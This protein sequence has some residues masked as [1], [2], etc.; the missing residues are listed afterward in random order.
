MITG[1]Y[2]DNY[3]ILESNTVF[4]FK[5]QSDL[6]LHFEFN[7][8]EKF[9]FNLR[10]IFETSEDAHN[11]KIGASENE[12]KIICNNFDDIVGTGSLE[13]I[14]IATVDDKRLYIHVWSS[15]HGRSDNGYGAREVVYT[16]FIER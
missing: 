9:E 15:L 5:P 11:M 1:I 13:P 7:N 6:I 4:L 16:V 14:E 10:I 8:E 3:E 12:I 2:T